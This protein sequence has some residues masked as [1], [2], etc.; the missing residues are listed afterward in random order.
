MVFEN[1]V[2][3]EF[4]QVLK[5]LASPDPQEDFLGPSNGCLLSLLLDDQFE[6]HFALLLD[7]LASSATEQKSAKTK[8]NGKNRCDFILAPNDRNLT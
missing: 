6:D 3:L 8:T 1:L 4:L 5:K 7:F 2:S